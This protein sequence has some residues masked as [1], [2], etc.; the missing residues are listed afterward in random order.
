MSNL[1]LKSERQI[2]TRMLAK[3]IA[4][5]SLNDINPGSVIDRITQAAAQ[6]DFA[7]YYQLAQVSRLADVEALTGDDLDLKAF[8]YGI[9]RRA[10]EK[11]TGTISILRP[12]GFVKVSTTFYAGFPAP[13]VGDT[14]IFVNNA[15]SVLIGSTGTL[16]LGRGTNNEEETT[17]SIAPTNNINY[18]TFQLDSPLTK[19]HA[20]E[21][22]V[23]LKQGTDQPILAGTTVIVSA[24]GTNEE[25]QFSTVNDETL[26]AGED[27][28]TG[29]E[30]IAVEPGT[31]GNISSGS[32]SGT[33]AFPTPPFT[34]ARATNES[35][36]TTGRD[37]ETDDQLRDRIKDAVQALSRG[38]KQAILNAIVGLV[39]PVTAKR[40]VSA[41]VVLPVE[42]VG[43]VKVYIDDGT[44]F[45][46]SF[47]SQGFEVVKASSTGGEQRLQTDQFPVVKAQ[48]EN[49]QVEP[50]DMSGGSKTLTVEVG[51]LTETITFQPSDFRFPD[52]ATA[53]EVSAAINDKSTLLEAR[54]SQIGK[55]VV[56]TAKI[57]KN[58]NLQVT[59]GSANAILSF[60]T[61]RKDTINLYIDDVK[62]SKDGATAILDSGNSA[63]YNLLALGAYPH[64]LT[65]I[66]DGKSANPQTAT[67]DLIDVDDPAAVTVLEI[68]AVINRDIA[69]LTATPID[70]NTIVRLESNTKLS[71]GSKIQ[72]T[73]GSMNDSTNGL[74]FST[75]EATGLPGDYIFNRELGIIQLMMAL[76]LN[77]SVTIGSLFTRAKLRATNA[78]LYSPAAGQTLVISVDNG[79]DQTIAFDGTFAAGKTAQQTALFINGQL[80]GATAIVRTVGIN[81]Y[82]EINSNTYDLTGSLEVKSSST[83]N[84]AFGFPLDE[85]VFSDKPNKAYRVSSQPGPFAFAENDSLVVV[86]DDDIVN[87]TF[88]VLMNAVRSVTLGTSTT[89]FRDATLN[90]LFETSDQIKDYFVAFTSGP[91]T[92]S[93]TIT[94]VA[95]QGGGIVRYTF[96]VAPANFADFAIGDLAKI[97]GLDDPENNLNA[98]ITAKG[99]DYIEVSNS[100]GINATTQTG[101]GVL[102]QK[103]IVTAYNQGT[104][105]ITVGVPFRATPISGNGL[106]VMPRTTQNVVEYMNNTKITSLSVKAEIEGVNNNTQVQITSKSQGSDGYV[107]VTGGSAND[108]LGF[109]VETY[110]GLAGYNY[111]TGLVKLVHKTIYGDDTD[112]V[113]FPGFGAAGII[114]QILAPTVKNIS[115]ELDVT[116]REGVSISSIE[117]E[118]RSAVTGYVNNLGVG[119]DIVI[120]EI[121]AAVIAINGIIDVSI[122]DPSAN[123]AIADNE[124]ARVADSDILVG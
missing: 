15:S 32:I 29:V 69:G 104:G 16:I 2:Q 83:G 10:A 1:T 105:Q 36:Y 20:T 56:I 121:R 75:A 39:D 122:S 21:E 85:E 103:R 80:R 12:E 14:Q 97:T 7:L 88:A 59:G 30:V 23:I 81:N 64:T 99:A 116:L 9:T 55:K 67:I 111:W 89:V 43:P 96:S 112:L 86:I 5:L 53:E 110:R 38:V 120:E 52:I 49:N 48:I 87:N 37:R 115:V 101:T 107:Q 42:D 51:T 113:S 47:A 54:T 74:N 68:C 50:Y 13:I 35:K 109:V 118:V 90:T 34:G 72:V 22:T 95:V 108:K 60:P 65:L 57:D 17:Y 102:S 78:E 25:I 62:L 61:D 31:D 93:G 11:A 84:G 82:V 18:Y 119:D 24:T 79:A 106:L 71:A 73:G 46:P 19:N 27:K 91:N 40:V 8:E 123:I 3:L 58:E 76:G 45:E 70:T 124:L 63:P 94:T 77:Q 98:V 28:V 66:I 6:N 114:F 92:T 44:G 100:D 26:L 117:N 4:Q 33:S 41:S